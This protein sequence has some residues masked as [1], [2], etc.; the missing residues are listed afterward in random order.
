MEASLLRAKV[1]ASLAD[2]VSWGMH[3][4]AIEENEFQGPLVLYPRSNIFSVVRKLARNNMDTRS[5][6]LGSPSQLIVNDSKAGRE[7]CGGFMGGVIAANDP[8]GVAVIQSP[9]T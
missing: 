9:F 3:E 5:K 2:G 7:C 8:G 4:D 6:D 1:K